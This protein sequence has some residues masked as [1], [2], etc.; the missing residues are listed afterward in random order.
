MLTLTPNRS[1]KT[2]AAVAMIFV[3]SAAVISFLLSCS[4]ACAATI[5][6]P[7]DYASIQDAIN[8]ASPGDSV[9]IKQGVYDQG[10]ILMKDEVSLIGEALTP[11]GRV[12]TAE[13]VPQGHLVTIR[14]S[15]FGTT[16][17]TIEL[18][19]GVDV[20]ITSWSGG[21]I[22]FVIPNCDINGDGVVS[23]D[24]S[25]VPPLVLV[26]PLNAPPTPTNPQDLNRDRLVNATDMLIIRNNIGKVIPP[27]G[28]IKVLTSTGDLYYFAYT[29]LNGAYAAIGVAVIQGKVTAANNV[30]ISKLTIK[31]LRSTDSAVGMDI[32]SNNVTVTNVIVHCGN[33]DQYD[34][35]IYLHNA[36][37]VVIKNC[38]LRI[39]A[40]EGATSPEETAC[41][42]SQNSQ[43]K[44]MDNILSMSDTA[45]NAINSTGDTPAIE[46]N[47]I[48]GKLSPVT[49][50]NKGTIFASPGFVDPVNG[51]FTL[52][53]AAENMRS[54]S[55]ALDAG[56]PAS[57]KSEEVQLIAGNKA[58]D[59]G[60]YGNT[61]YTIMVA[62]VADINLDGVV[63]D[64]DASI[65]AANWHTVNKKRSQGDITGDGKVNDA[66]ASVL[67]AW[68]GNLAMPYSDLAY[69]K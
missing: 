69:R 34:K 5:T 11:S 13:D 27:A 14:G 12:E 8:N 58:I 26:G 44:L 15:G 7:T 21:L 20:V 22:T 31:N 52:K 56:D 67:A 47:C 36:Q 48:L 35:G 39:E 2:K 37:N 50:A 24:D 29:D 68:W 3:I 46:Y 1:I 32:G 17:G 62:C 25:K 55:V 19:G 51:N 18:V 66:D 33:H 16:K 45:L 49:L 4:N 64:R 10:D 60:A 41:V 30:G 54:P 23:A 53:M 59:L 6:V 28:A 61:R 9:F 40:K 65:L 38:T 63:N 42:Y 43:Y 57:D